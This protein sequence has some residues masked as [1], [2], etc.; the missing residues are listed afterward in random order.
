MLTKKCRGIWRDSKSQHAT[1]ARS[2]NILILLPLIAPHLGRLHVGGTLVV[3]LG[4]HA[5]DGDEDLFD[6]LDGGPA[7]G[8]VFVVVWVVAGGV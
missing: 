2:N 8:G 4:K 7:L 3:G 5:H 6:G 1:N